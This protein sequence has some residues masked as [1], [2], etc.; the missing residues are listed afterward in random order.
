[1]KKTGQTKNQVFEESHYRWKSSEIS[2]HIRRSQS[3]NLFVCWYSYLVGNCLLPRRSSSR[4]SL[5]GRQMAFL[6]QACHRKSCSAPNG[7]DRRPRSPASRPFSPLHPR[8]NFLPHGPS[9]RGWGLHSGAFESLGRAL[10]VQKWYP[11]WRLVRLSLWHATE[12]TSR[13]VF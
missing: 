10:A 4:W 2:P 3:K 6:L 11:R 8:Q 9:I 7:T 13:F 1:M 5:G 12:M